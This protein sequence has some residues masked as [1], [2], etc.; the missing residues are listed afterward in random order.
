MKLEKNL[1]LIIGPSKEFLAR[2]QRAMGRSLKDISK[3][4]D[5]PVTSLRRL[6]DDI[7][8]TDEQKKKLLSKRKNKLIKL[9]YKDNSITIDGRI[10]IKL[11]KKKNLTDNIDELILKYILDILH[12]HSHSETF[13]IG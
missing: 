2:Q 13:V 1:N 7:K 11:L 8:L 12:C 4:F 5:I 6:C 3:E 9:N 10:K